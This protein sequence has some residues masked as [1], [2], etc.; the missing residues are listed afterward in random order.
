VADFKYSKVK[1][2]ENMLGV[3]DSKCGRAKIVK[4]NPPTTGDLSFDEYLPFLDGVM[5]PRYFRLKEAKRAVVAVSEG[6]PLPGVG[7]PAF[8]QQAPR[9][10]AP[11]TASDHQAAY[12][13]TVSAFKARVA[14]GS[15]TPPAPKASPY[16]LLEVATTATMDECRR[17]YRKMVKKYHPDSVTGD[18]EK[19]KDIKEAWALLQEIEAA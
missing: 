18:E 11:G 13:A 8:Q 2:D 12:D 1:F 16:T 7:S 14:G 3:R 15:R 10:T 6:K 4:L 17:A 19:F 5:L 9:T